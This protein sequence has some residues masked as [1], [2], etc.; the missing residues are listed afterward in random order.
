MNI[1]V[2]RKCILEIVNDVGF[3]YKGKEYFITPHSEKSF[4]LRIDGA[5]KSY[6]DIDEL[7]TDK[8]VDGKSISEMV[9]EL[10]FDMC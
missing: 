8:V 2:L 6:T 1:K 3:C 5:K 10:D 4:T 7:L 9:N